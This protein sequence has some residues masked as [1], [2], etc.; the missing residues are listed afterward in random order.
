MFFV[1]FF[2][3]VV[4]SLG[5]TA[6]LFWFFEQPIKG[7]E[8]IIILA[9]AKVF[10]MVLPPNIVVILLLKYIYIKYILQYLRGVMEIL[11]CEISSIMW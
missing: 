8:N 5:D 10:F 4:F 9:K 11:D 7:K 3:I 2:D 1:I 6:C